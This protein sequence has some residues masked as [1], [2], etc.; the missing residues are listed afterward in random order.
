MIGRV[1][2]ITRCRRGQHG[3]VLVGV[4]ITLAVVAVVAERAVTWVSTRIQRDAEAE[5]AFLGDQF[6]AAV[7]R[8]YLSPTGT[9]NE[10]PR[11]LDHLILDHRR[12]VTIRHLRRV[13]VDPLTGE[14]RWGVLYG[15]LLAAPYGLPDRAVTEGPPV[16]GIVGFFSLSSRKPFRRIDA[17][18]RPIGCFSDWRFVVPAVT[19]LIPEKSMVC[20]LEGNVIRCDPFAGATDATLPRCPG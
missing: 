9:R 6:T 14:P 3:A 11:S 19:E 1:D 16:E 20:A 18:G 4:L 12:L 7:R 15:R 5:L 10:L 2:P 13:P 17:D 8:Y